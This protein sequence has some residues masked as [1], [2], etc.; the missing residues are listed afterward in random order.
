MA[1]FLYLGMRIIFLTYN[2]DKN[3]KNWRNVYS[4]FM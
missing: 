4:K 1:I 2:T 3:L